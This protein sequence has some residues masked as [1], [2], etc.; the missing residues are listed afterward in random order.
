MYLDD[1]SLE[2]KIKINNILKEKFLKNPSL[3]I[4]FTEDIQGLSILLEELNQRSWG[5][6]YKTK[7]NGKSGHFVAVSF[8]PTNISSCIAI[9]ESKNQKKMLWAICEAIGSTIE[10]YQEYDL[11]FNKK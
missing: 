11:F 6:I 4:D 3:S 8:P 2:D 1:Q 5:F 10:S 7:E 9:V